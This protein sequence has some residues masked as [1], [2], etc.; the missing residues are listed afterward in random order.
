MTEKRRTLIER[1]RD[2][3]DFIERIDEPFPKS[4]FQKIGFNPDTA[5]KWLELIAYIQHKPRIRL[6][7]TK[8][9]TI[10]ECT[11]KDYH[12]RTREVFMDPTRSYKER[13]YALESYLAALITTERLKN[14]TAL[15]H[16]INQP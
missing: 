6:V 3:F 12:T 15:K 5:E 14:P 10:V 2:I 7:K 11:E 4:K 1:A 13:Y 9:S 16:S 8:K